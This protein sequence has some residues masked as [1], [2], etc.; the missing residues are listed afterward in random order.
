VNLKV[1]PLSVQ[2]L[3]AELTHYESEFG[4]PSAAFASAYARGDATEILEETALDWLM[5]YEA[6]KLV[7]GADRRPLL[8]R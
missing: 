4:M 7:S 8:D 1:E 2:D 5:A 6:W 3:E